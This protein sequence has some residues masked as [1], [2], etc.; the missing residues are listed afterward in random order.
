[1]SKFNLEK[2]LEKARFVTQ[3]RNI[4]NVKA[5]VLMDL[6]VS[7]SARPLFTSGQMQSAFERVLPIG[8][9]F[10]DNGE[11]DVF[12][13]QSSDSIYRVKETATS[14]NY[15]DYITRQILRNPEV[16]LWGGTDYA[17]VIRENLEALGFYNTE[18]KAAKSGGL[19]SRM[20]GGGTVVTE[21]KLQPTSE[22]GHPAIIY[23]F[24]DGENSDKA[25]TTQLLQECQD[26]K[27]NAYFMFI[28]IGDA[29][30][31]YIEQLGDKFDNT[32]FLNIRDLSKI[33]DE[34][35][36]DLLLPEELCTWLRNKA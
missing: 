23:F 19:F 4:P 20:F 29:N 34:T 17:P 27:V 21:K 5:Q 24:T 9:I 12:T 2:S 31:R 11:I 32:G 35:I 8:I 15:T 28:G 3:K 33:D 25:A 30:F 7:G 10:D 26:N 6:D 14:K 18:T 13:F 16:P 36:Y 1:M 22:S